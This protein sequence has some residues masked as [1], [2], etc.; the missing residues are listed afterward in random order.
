M[1][2]CSHY[3]T[4]ASC[5]P[6]RSESV[7]EGSSGHSFTSIR[8][9]ITQRDPSTHSLRSF[10]QDDTRGIGHTGCWGMCV[11]YN[12]YSLFMI[13]K[14]ILKLIEEGVK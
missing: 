4:I 5:H 8:I 2:F 9:N 11:K 10:A 7:V 6:E 13:M 14:Y 3:P 12:S 1:Y